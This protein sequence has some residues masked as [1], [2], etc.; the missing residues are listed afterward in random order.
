MH[1]SGARGHVG[2]RMNPHRNR[3]YCCMASGD[4]YL[5]AV[6]MHTKV[7]MIEWHGDRKFSMARSLLFVMASGDVCLVV[8]S[9]HT[10]VCM[11]EWH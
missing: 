5:A 4:V 6:S 9:I 8:A 10:N 7:C 2:S 1:L 3:I 11:I